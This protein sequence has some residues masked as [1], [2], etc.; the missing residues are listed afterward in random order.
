MLQWT[1]DWVGQGSRPSP[2]L[3]HWLAVSLGRS[4]LTLGL[5][6]LICKMKGLDWRTFKIFPAWKFHNRAHMQGLWL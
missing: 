4:L 5:S 2:S 1:L 6:F 3:C